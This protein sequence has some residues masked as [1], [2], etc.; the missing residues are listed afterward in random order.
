MKRIIF[1]LAL[2]IS[3][4]ATA[5]K[6]LP[7]ILDQDDQQVRKASAPSSV[8]RDII[9][10]LLDDIAKS[11]PNLFATY[12]NPAWI[13]SYDWTKLINTPTSLSSAG[14]TSGLKTINS[15]S[16][17]GSGDISISGGGI[18]N[19]AGNTE[20]PVSDG[21]NIIS[22]GI[23]SPSPGNLQVGSNSISGSKT[24]S[25][26][27]S[28]TN[29]DLTLTPKGTGIVNIGTSGAN[30]TSGM[31]K[32]EITN[33]G[34]VN[35]NQ[36]S[37][38][39]LGNTPPLLDTAGF[40]FVFDYTTGQ[41]KKR[42]VSTIG[43]GGSSLPSQTKNGGNYLTT[44]GSYGTPTVSWKVPV[45]PAI[46]NPSSDI[47]FFGT[48]ITAGLNITSTSGYA[49]MLSDQLGC[50]FTNYA[51]SSSQWFTA[52]EAAYT[53]ISPKNSNP[54]I[55][56]CG[57]N[58]V[59][60]GGNTTKTI[61]QMKSE[62][63]AFLLNQFA[64]S[65]VSA[66]SGS[67]TK[68][69][70]WTTPTLAI[71]KS[72][73]ALGGTIEQSIVSGSTLTWT[74]TGESFGIGSFS[75]DEVNQF[76]G[77]FT[78]SIDGGASVTYT[79]KSKASG[80]PDGTGTPYNMQIV[81]NAICFFNLGATSHT[82]VVTTNST[83]ATRVDYFAV[84]KNPSYAAP[85]I[86]L[87]IPKMNAAGYAIT[88]N[89]SDAIM[90]IG[91]SAQFS[92]AAEFSVFG[93]PVFTYDINNVYNV[94]TDVQ[95]DNVHPNAQP[96]NQHWASGIISV[97]KPGNS[98]SPSIF[99]VDNSSGNRFFIA[100]GAGG[101]AFGQ[102]WNPNTGAIDNTSAG[103]AQVQLITGSG[104]GRVDI[105]TSHANNVSPTITTT[106]DK[107]GQIVSNVGATT[108]KTYFTGTTGASNMTWNYN[109]AAN[110]FDDVTLPGAM[111]AMGGSSANSEIDFF[112]S[113]AN[114]TTLPLSL[115]LNNL[116]VLQ[117]PRTLN[118]TGVRVMTTDA[119][120]NVGVS[121]A[122]S[123]TLN[124]AGNTT[125][126]ATTSL[127][128][129][130][131]N[132]SFA[133]S[134]GDTFQYI[135]NGS[136]VASY[137]NTGASDAI[138]F[139]GG[140]S[141]NIAFLNDA[142][143]NINF[144]AGGASSAQFTIGATGV[145]NIGV[146]PVRFDTVY[147]ILGWKAD[148]SIVRVPK[149]ILG[150]SATWGAISG[151][152]T[153][154]SDLVSYVAAQ[155]AANAIGQVSA[156]TL[157]YSPQGSN[158]TI[159]IIGAGG[160]STWVSY[161]PSNNLIN[162]GT[163]LTIPNNTST[164]LAPIVVYY[165]PSSVMTTH[166]IT[167]PSAP[168]DGQEVEIVGG[169]TITTGNPVVTTFSVTANSGQ[170]LYQ[171]AA[172]STLNGNDKYVYKYIAG[173]STWYRGATAS[174]GMTN[175]MTAVGQMIRGGTSGTPTA[176]S[177]GT[178]GQFLTNSAG[179][180]AWSTQTLTLGG[181]LTTSGAFATTLTAT[182]TTTV[183]LPTS[184]TLATVAGSL[185]SG[186]T[187]A[188]TAS[189]GTSG[190]FPYTFGNNSLTLTQPAQTSVWAP[191]ITVTSGAHTSE[192]ASTEFVTMKWD[193]SPTISH[194][195]GAIGTLRSVQGLA[196]TH[197]AVASSTFSNPSFMSFGLPKMGN[198]AVGTFV[199]GLTIESTNVVTGTGAASKAV[200]ISINSITGA[201]NNYSL[202]AAND[203]LLDA[204]LVTAGTAPTFTAGTAAGTAPTVT[205]T[206]NDIAGVVNVTTGTAPT[207]TPVVTVTFNTAYKAA[208]KA[209][210]LTPASSAA[211]A[212]SGLT[213]VYVDPT[214]TTTAHYIITVGGTGLA[215]A[216]AYSWYYHIFQ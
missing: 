47:K 9:A 95:V 143:G 68:A 10:T 175:P 62:E 113:N 123:L 100:N 3:F 43:G 158:S 119:S 15:Q 190:A 173:T 71:S 32:I 179:I 8:T 81:P 16:L 130:V 77:D 22:S 171:T 90:E 120:G 125:I 84:L 44:D 2:L 33:A 195:T 154:Q 178:A 122:G 67:V 89:V 51:V 26:A 127:S 99:T 115:K 86:M 12:P 177:A 167:M 188:L 121:S 34:R 65:F 69:G 172:P 73:L 142:S 133:N 82:V 79:G 6:S 40:V 106:F 159:Q 169:G 114:N 185:S 174:A 76:S 107:N 203:V 93:F 14:I 61:E 160:T 205:I 164:V 165:N 137:K 1:L 117:L 151:T 170:V 140:S 147:N 96:G 50:T 4:S 101:G 134:S 208:P 191:A 72:S 92:V 144:A 135:I 146:K 36:T 13:P 200:G 124:S 211:A 131:A 41:V 193:F 24:I 17:F 59:R 136:G 138:V 118:G 112:T 5:Q 45:G 20:I 161:L 183:T 128:T 155:I 63:R 156:S 80:V 28:S 139:H 176:I 78:I 75:T 198:F 55:V 37:L 87:S 202:E 181:N 48:S 109:P 180:P 23:F 58:D 29:A 104:F 186:A 46:F 189:A 39:I 212:L 97:I 184:G 53:S 152:L 148:G 42:H 111:V 56:E 182:G 129:G 197:V 54:S 70:T 52:V 210:I 94:A 21:T 88:G 196:P 60:A 103:T 168:L 74:F 192:T 49:A 19:T 116:G 98:V 187:T 157:G 102:N 105:L 110:T 66:S 150:G 85:V 126:S 149:S 132:M 27:S 213:M 7:A 216:T 209:V 30:M 166:A 11:S 83:T 194:L 25:V 201:T 207:G 206:G 57:F 214:N 162:T 145:I 199:A 91:T 108:A 141:G 18:T 64:A 153:S 215:S 31:N 35:L 38:Y 163:S 204:H